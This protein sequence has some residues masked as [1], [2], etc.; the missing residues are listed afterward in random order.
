MASTKEKVIGLINLDIF[1][2]QEL[3]Q[4]LTMFRNKTH[5]ICKTCNTQKHYDEFAK[6]RKVCK[7]C[8]A[9]RNKNYYQNNKIKWK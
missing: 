7:L 5:K 6:N 9:D 1:D 2:E 8:M 4:I 3:L